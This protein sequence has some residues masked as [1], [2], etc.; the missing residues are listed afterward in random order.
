MSNNIQFLE[1]FRQIHDM[2]NSVSRILYQKEAMRIEKA[3]RYL[4]K[5]VETCEF[6]MCMSFESLEKALSD[7]EIKEMSET[8]TGATIGGIEVRRK[9]I[10][11]LYN[12]DSTKYSAKEQPKYGFLVGPDRQRDLY[13]D[14]DAFYHYGQVLVT[15]RKENM[16]ERTTMTVG[17]SLNFNES[18]LK[19]PTFVNDPKFICIKGLPKKPELHGKP[20]FMGLNFFTDYLIGEKELNPEYPNSMA[21]LS[22]DELGF[23]NFELQFFGKI[24]FSEDVKDLHYIEI[25]GNSAEHLEK[26]GPLLKKYNLS[27]KEL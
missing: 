14:P 15:F 11:D 3:E 17:S 23:E 10:F 7:N 24:T 2:R 16:I 9:A 19:T 8:G 4:K 25:G 20:Y 18:A 13:K 1:D 22:N 26:I 12:L 6:C 5:V 27:C 21:M